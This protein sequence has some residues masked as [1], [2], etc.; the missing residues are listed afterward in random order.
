[1]MPFAALALALAVQ[2]TA[3]GRLTFKAP[4]GWIPRPAASTM[5]VAE[6]VLP[7]AAGDSE[8]GDLVVYFFGGQGGDVD[9]NINR[10]IG[11]MQQPGGGSSA[12]VAKRESKTING[13]AVTLLEVAGTYVAEKSPGSAEHFNKPGFRMRTAVVQ[14]P[15]GPHFIKML[16]PEKTVARWTAGFAAFLDSLRFE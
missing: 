12:Q 9:A 10:W 7:R 16:G 5:R 15:K 8:D 13:M 3:G 4:E 2:T 6:F 1:M 14:T 11:Q